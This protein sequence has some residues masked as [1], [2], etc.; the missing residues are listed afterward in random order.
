MWDGNMHRQDLLLEVAFRIYDAI[1]FVKPLDGLS[2]VDEQFDASP[3][4]YL[5][6]FSRLRAQGYPPCI[7]WWCFLSGTTLSW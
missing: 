3:F 4:M 1:P 7:S 6:R 2:H 5:L